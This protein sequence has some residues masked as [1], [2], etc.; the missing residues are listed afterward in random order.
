MPMT[1][2]PYNDPGYQGTRV[3][4][5]YFLSPG[6]PVPW[7]LGSVVAWFRGPL[8]PL[9]R[10]GLPDSSRAPAA[11]HR[12]GGGQP[13]AHIEGRGGAAGLNLPRHRGIEGDIP[14][15]AFHGLLEGGAQHLADFHLGDIN[16][17]ADTPRNPD[18]SV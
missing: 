3:H 7:S 18:S 2:P 9:N 10:Q 8:V 14:G 17:H 12:R 5:T 13:A 11:D 15:S 1:G 16:T 4:F 6:P